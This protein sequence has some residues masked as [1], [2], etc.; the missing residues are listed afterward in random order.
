MMQTLSLTTTTTIPCIGQT[1]DF[2]WPCPGHWT[3]QDYQRLPEDGRRYEIIDGVLY[4]ANAPSYEH[5]YTVTA[6]AHLFREHVM[7][8][9]LGVV[10][11]APFEIHLS[12]LTVQ[13]ALTVTSNLRP[14]SVLASVNTG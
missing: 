3:Y 14:M 12:D 8:R 4:M 1:H 11:V 10:L 6:L 13:F 9:Q 2:Q 7:Q 5:Q